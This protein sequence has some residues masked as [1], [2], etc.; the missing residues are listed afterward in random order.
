M[1]VLAG[2]PT[3]LATS[4]LVLT[5][6]RPNPGKEVPSVA[7]PLSRSDPPT[8]REPRAGLLAIFVL[9]LTLGWL[10]LIAYTIHP[11]LPPNLIRLPFEDKSRVSA[12]LQQGWTFFATDPRVP[13]L[14]AY[15]LS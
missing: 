8:T 3:A 2:A 10:V 6:A 9:G 15:L 7:A 14:S 1:M 4:R 12:L 5:S 13:T 11:Q